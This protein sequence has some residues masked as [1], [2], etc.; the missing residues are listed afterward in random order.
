MPFLHCGGVPRLSSE[1]FSH[2]CSHYYLAVNWL[3]VQY[4]YGMALFQAALQGIFFMT[5]L[6]LSP[7]AR[8]KWE[9]FLLT[10]VSWCLVHGMDGFVVSTP[11]LDVLTFG[12]WGLHHNFY[13]SLLQRRFPSTNQANDRSID[14]PIF[15]LSICFFELQNSSRIFDRALP[16]PTSEV[17]RI[18]STIKC[19]RSPLCT[20]YGWLNKCDIAAPQ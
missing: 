15:T 13:R 14:L 2:S 19:F 10:T 5:E 12:S 16:D 1:V 20:Y 7:Y 17:S 9:A 8:N 4:L 11:S 18:P 3:K 6:V